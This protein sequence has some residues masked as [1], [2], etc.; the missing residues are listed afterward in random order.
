MQMIA[1]LKENWVRLVFAGLNFTATNG[2][3]PLS[4]SCPPSSTS[5]TPI[6]LAIFPPIRFSLRFAL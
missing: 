3:F 5:I 2:P 4:L 6:F 1:I